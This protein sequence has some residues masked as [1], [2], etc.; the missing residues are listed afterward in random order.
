MNDTERTLTNASRIR[1]RF[2]PTPNGPLH[3]GSL[4]TAVASWLQV[5]R[6]GG[7]WWVRIDDLDH[8]R[9]VPGMAETLLHQLTAYGLVWDAAPV[10]QS[11][12]IAHYRAA[13]AQLQSDG[14]VY[15]CRCTR[16]AI[17][18]RGGTPGLPHYDQHCWRHPIA[19][20]TT[21]DAWRLALENHLM[22]W[23]DAVH[24]H[25]HVT[26]DALGDPVVWRRDGLAGYPL[27]CAVDEAD[28]GITDVLRGDDL[29]GETH[30]QVQI[31]RQLGLSMPRYQHIAVVRDAAGHK[32]S[33]HRHAPPLPDDEPG[34]AA[35]MASTL[36]SLVG[37]VPHELRTATPDE[38]LRWALQQPA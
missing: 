10:Y 9:C 6:R 27:A 30:A 12:R 13:F 32:L 1:G 16:R 2:A 36:S 14:R 8:V 4:R 31:A 23:H 33:K 19:R 34:R 20:P 3:L 22:D 15:A 11:S 26:R 7:E 29:L 18:A 5:R 17:H 21:D 37:S 24:G 25:C 35:A 38:Q 28:L